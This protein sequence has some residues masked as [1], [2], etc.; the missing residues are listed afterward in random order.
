MDWVLTKQERERALAKRH[1]SVKTTLTSKSK[2]LKPLTVGQLVQVQNQRG[3]HANKWDLS[4]VITEV[5]PYDSY[6]IKMDGSGR[7]TKRNRQFIKTII[8]FITPYQP[9]LP[10]QTFIGDI[11]RETDQSQF[12]VKDNNDVL[13]PGSTADKAGRP[14]INDA[15]TAAAVPKFTQQRL[16]DTDT[17]TEISMSDQ[18]F[19][20]GLKRA[21]QKVLKAN[22][23]IQPEAGPKSSTKQLSDTDSGSTS[24]TRNKRVKF[25]TKRLIENV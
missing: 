1:L 13:M 20:S 9:S 12:K 23:N 16:P 7:V 2:A 25:A 15:S 19:N 14:S 24:S 22:T 18:T 3:P 8:P 5:L 11:R 21:V 17:Q 4:G 10:N 6:L